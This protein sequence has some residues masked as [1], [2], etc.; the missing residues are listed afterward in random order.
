MTIL[1]SEPR[2]PAIPRVRDVILRDG[3]TLRL[4]PP[5]RSDAG[6]LVLFFQALAATSLFARFHG[7]PPVDGAL[8]EP[9]LDP[10][11]VECGALMATT[12]GDDDARVVAIA[13]YARLRD[14]S[15]A[16]VAFA[17]ADSM[18]A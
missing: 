12:G 3:T 15:M 8:V 17:V 6:A 14:P 1:Q 9:Y 10:D 4:R 13:S 18:Q 7:M 11:W 2:A 16:E 5:A